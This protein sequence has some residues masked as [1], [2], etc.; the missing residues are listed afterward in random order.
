MHTPKLF[1]TISVYLSSVS[2]EF[3]KQDNIIRSRPFSNRHNVCHV[4]SSRTSLFYVIKKYLRI[5][6]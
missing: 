2:M 4:Q 3:Y 1:Y 6:R 5:F